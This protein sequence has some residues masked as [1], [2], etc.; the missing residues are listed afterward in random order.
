MRY[1]VTPKSSSWRRDLSIK[2]DKSQ[3]IF[4][5]E[6][7]Y[8]SSQYTLRDVSG[9]E[10]AFIQQKTPLWGLSFEVFKNKQSFAF[11]KKKPFVFFKDVFIVEVKG[12]ETLIVEGDYGYLKYKFHRAEKLIAVSNRK[13]HS[14]PHN[15]MVDILEQDDDLLILAC[16]IMFYLDVIDGSG[17]GGQG[18]WI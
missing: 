14:K 12:S 18:G 3:E 9:N 17:R 5:A 6:G 2:N 4:R 10:V 8:L 7:A 1:I 11:I 15:Y 16:T 13:R